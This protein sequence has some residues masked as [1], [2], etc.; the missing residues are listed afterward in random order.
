MTARGRCALLLLGT[1]LLLVG[2]TSEI[3]TQATV[4]ARSGAYRD[5]DGVK[6]LLRDEP[7]L[8]GEPL[9]AAV[10][11]NLQDDPLGSLLA[12]EVLHDGHV[13]TYMVYNG[14]AQDGGGF[15]GNSV[16]V[17]LCVSLTV[18]PTEATVQLENAECSGEAAKMPDDTVVI[19]LS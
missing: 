1:T 13:R 4:S 8:R 18:N 9:L 19:G 17:R 6:I 12:G 3:E 15:T 11:E 7:S 14:S 16:S 5:R 10:T 2:C